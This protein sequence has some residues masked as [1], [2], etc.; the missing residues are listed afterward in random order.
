MS[1]EGTVLRCTA[2]G[3]TQTGPGATLYGRGGEWL[4]GA[5]C[6]E[7]DAEAAR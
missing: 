5:C 2:C 3:A 1:A 7:Y 6:D 4:C